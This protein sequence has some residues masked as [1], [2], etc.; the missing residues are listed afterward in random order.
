MAQC[1]KA[2]V[3]GIAA[4]TNYTAEQVKA[5][6]DAKENNL[7][8]LIQ[9]EGAATR[10]SIQTVKD[11]VAEANKTL[12][13]IDGKCTK[14]L[15]ILKAMQRDRQIG[16]KANRDQAE[17]RQYTNCNAIQVANNTQCRHPRRPQSDHRQGLGLQAQTLNPPLSLQT[18]APY[19][20]EPYMHNWCRLESY[21]EVD[22]MDETGRPVNNVLIVNNRQCNSWKPC[23]CS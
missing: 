22:E 14:A 7:Q 13:K 12:A 16:D 6:M 1:E 20:L 8:N 17:V 23:E 5:H 9:T 15:D 21:L 3:E 19:E 18:Q 10:H 2:A 11:D 4:C